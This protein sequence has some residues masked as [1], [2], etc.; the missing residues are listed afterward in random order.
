MEDLKVS[1]NE[2]K[3]LITFICDTCHASPG[4][5]G[6]SCMFS[7]NVQRIAEALVREYGYR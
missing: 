5:N 2:L 1:V 7:E 6:C 4:G 3:M